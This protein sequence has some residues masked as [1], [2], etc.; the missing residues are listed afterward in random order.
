MAIALI[1]I[2]HTLRLPRIMIGFIVGLFVQD[3]VSE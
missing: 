2:E 1:V 3:D